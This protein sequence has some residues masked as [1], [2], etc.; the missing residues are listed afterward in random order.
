[1][2]EVHDIESYRVPV[3]SVSKSTLL[4][5]KNGVK[6]HLPCKCDTSISMEEDPEQSHLT[7][8]PPIVYEMAW[9]RRYP[10]VVQV[11]EGFYF[12]S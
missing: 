11:L 1:M 4:F 7:V 2:V 12:G 3:Y 8:R 5:G 6:K 9:H 10:S